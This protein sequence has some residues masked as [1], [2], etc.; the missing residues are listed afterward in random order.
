MEDLSGFFT[1]LQEKALAVISSKLP[2]ILSC[3]FDF[4]DSG[5]ALRSL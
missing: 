2:L 5:H 3:Q 1:G 4:V